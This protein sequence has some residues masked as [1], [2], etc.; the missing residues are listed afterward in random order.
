METQKSE[1]NLILTGAHLGSWRL[2]AD[3]VGFNGRYCLMADRP[4]GN[5]IELLPFFGKLAP[6]D[7]SPF[8]LAANQE[9]PLAFSFGV[10]NGDGYNF[11]G[12]PPRNY[13]FDRR[14]PREIQIFE[15]TKSFVHELE[16][17][18]ARYPDQWCNLYPYWSALP[19][20]KNSS[21]NQ[22]V[23]SLLE[24][25]SLPGVAVAAEIPPATPHEESRPPEINI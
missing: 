12:H 1:R 17:L 8:I 14:L 23:C 6:F 20:A 7:V 16:T 2:A 3:L 11:I 24:E 5:A 10:K 21:L 4:R 22:T 18:I 9:L 25:L 15:W 19:M 13:V